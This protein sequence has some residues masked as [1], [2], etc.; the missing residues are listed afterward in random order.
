MYI[1]SIYM[2][3]TNFFWRDWSSTSDSAYSYIF[4]H[5]T[6]CLFVI[7]HICVP[8]LN[9]S[10]DLDAI[11]QVHLWGLMTYSVRWGFWLPEGEIWGSNPRPKHAIANCC[12]LVSSDTLLPGYFS[13]I[14]LPYYVSQLLIKVIY[15]W[16]D[17]SVFILVKLSHAYPISTAD[18]TAEYV[19]HKK[20]L[21]YNNDFKLMCIV[22]N[23]KQ[24]CA[25]IILLF[26]VWFTCFI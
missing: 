14:L 19:Q 6:V 18:V 9:R 20:N 11:R 26:D 24:N 21:L 13:L 3:R 4:I 8:C 5:S 23:Q 25:V 15:N 22:C 10:A 2:Y 12:I 16:P 7:C 17:V 1:L